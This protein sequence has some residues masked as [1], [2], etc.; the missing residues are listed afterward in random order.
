VP[1]AADVLEAHGFAGDRLLRLARR[2]AADE[3]RRRG[4]F[5]DHDRLEDL[6][7]FLCLHGVRAA[8]R[9]DPE[10]RQ[11]KYGQN[12]GRDTFSSYI[13][14]VMCHRVTDWYRSKAEGHGDRRYGL[15]NRVVLDGEMH[16]SEPGDAFDQEIAAR[17][18]EDRVDF[19]EA[20]AELA[21]RFQLSDEGRRGLHLLRLTVEGYH[22]V[23]T[24]TQTARKTAVAEITA[25]AASR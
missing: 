22:V 3:L 8:V 13:A 2:I 20:E 6:V 5:L 23:G 24:G 15:D 9:Y 7:S 17:R 4:A 18:A 1:T 11:V 21:E 19:D 14:D 10:R 16:Y 25:A 12:G